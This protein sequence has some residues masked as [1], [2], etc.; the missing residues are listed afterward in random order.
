[1]TTFVA[2]NSDNESGDRS[3]MDD[4]DERKKNGKSWIFGS[5]SK[6]LINR[7]TNLPFSLNVCDRQ[8]GSGGNKTAWSQSSLQK[9]SFWKKKGQKRTYQ[10]PLTIIAFM[11]SSIFV[12]RL[13]LFASSLLSVS[14]LLIWDRLS[15]ISIKCTRYV[16]NL[17]WSVHCHNLIFHRWIA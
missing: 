14:D 2:K 1:M 5:P 3:R 15:L 10:V 7:R 6:S 12:P 4:G 11:A 8:I 9:W 13:L 16:S 17:L